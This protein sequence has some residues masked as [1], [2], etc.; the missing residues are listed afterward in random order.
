MKSLKTNNRRYFKILNDPDY[1][2]TPG[3]MDSIKI[4]RNGGIVTDP[5][6]KLF[7]NIGS[8]YY[9]IY[10]T[11][12]ENIGYYH[13]YGEYFVEIFPIPGIA[14]K[15]CK[16]ED[17][18]GWYTYKLQYG[19]VQKLTVKKMLWFMENGADVTKCECS[20]M[21]KTLAF[22][23]EH[24]NNKWS[25]RLFQQT[26]IQ[27]SNKSEFRK[28]FDLCW[29]STKNVLKNGIYYDLYEMLKNGSFNLT[30]RKTGFGFIDELYHLMDSD[31]EIPYLNE[32][33][34]Q[35]LLRLRVE[36]PAVYEIT[37][38][39]FPQFKDAVKS[40]VDP[41]GFTYLIPVYNGPYDRY[42]AK[43]SSL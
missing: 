15:P 29:E 33:I 19:P 39:K 36:Y 26:M 30:I 42:R 22:L 41:D 24:P 23:D 11:D 3:E 14:M 43:D 5:N 21:Y 13:T 32:C 37:A 2:G 12:I 18:R 20:L 16:D 27:L 31:E 1:F 7:R 10:F 35:L 6:E 38:H 25:H 34:H 17:G 40:A 28:E 4:D 9:G 8:G